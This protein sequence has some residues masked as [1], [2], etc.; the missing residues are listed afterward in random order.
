MHHITLLCE[1]CFC[2]MFCCV[3]CRLRF[4]NSKITMAVS[5]VHFAADAV[6]AFLEHLIDPMLPAKLIDPSPSQ[7]KKVA[8]QVPSS[9]I[10]FIHHKP[11]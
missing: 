4:F 7:Q 8:Q 1:P 2:L 10:S 9:F 5:D 11:L 6:R 3:Q